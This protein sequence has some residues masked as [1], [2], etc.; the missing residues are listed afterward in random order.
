MNISF[1]TLKMHLDDY[2]TT[3]PE[4]FETIELLNWYLHG[5]KVNIAC[6]HILHFSM[7]TEIL[8]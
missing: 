4:M 3:D 5:C 6:I 2:L 1:S 8:C 7:E